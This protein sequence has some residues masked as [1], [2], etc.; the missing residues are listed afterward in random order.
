MKKTILLLSL[1]TMMLS[2]CSGAKQYGVD[3]LELDNF[4]F[5]LTIETFFQDER[6]FR[7]KHDDFSVSTTEHE[8]NDD[9]ISMMYI[10]YST[11]SMNV[12]RPLASYAGIKFESLGIITDEADEKVLMAIGS[13]R[14]AKAKDIETIINKL[15]S[16]NSTPEI[17]TETWA[18]GMNILFREDGGKVWNLYLGVSIDSEYEK[19]NRY[20]NR[21]GEYEEIK[22]TATD[23]EALKEKMKDMDQIACT[24]FVTTTYF[25]KALSDNSWYHGDMTQYN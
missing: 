15:H 1:V 20:Y 17:K 8:I 10:Q 22:F 16:V 12:S 25:D 21:Y 11:N 23:Y 18:R 7:G 19:H 24:L 5:N 6:I 4:D 3:V 13:T 2:A 14:Y 9:S